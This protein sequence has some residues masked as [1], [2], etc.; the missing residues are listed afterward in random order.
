MRKKTER[1]HNSKQGSIWRRA[2]GIE[3][4]VTKQVDELYQGTGTSQNMCTV[5]AVK[6]NK[7]KCLLP[8]HCRTLGSQSSRK[9]TETL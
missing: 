8:R 2:R 6:V 3:A 4:K 7:R 1:R 9:K 5:M